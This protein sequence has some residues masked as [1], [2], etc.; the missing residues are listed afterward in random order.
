MVLSVSLNLTT[1]SI[2]CKWNDAMFVFVAHLTVHFV[3]KFQ[4]E[5]SDTL[6]QN[7]FPF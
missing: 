6:H 1:L 2:S 4:V 3:L 5:A 7:F